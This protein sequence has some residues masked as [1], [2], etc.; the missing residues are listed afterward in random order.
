M[1]D[2]PK[3]GATRDAVLRLVL[4]AVDAANDSAPDG[5]RVPKE[6]DGKLIGP[7]GALDS[8]GLVGLLVAIEEKAQDEFGAALTLAD[9]RAFARERTPFRTLRTLVDYTHERLQEH[10]GG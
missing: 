8:L 3:T 1:V 6:L 9:E 5:H 2:E 4:A 7:G 10:R